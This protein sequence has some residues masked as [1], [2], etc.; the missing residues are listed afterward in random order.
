[1]SF[2]PTKRLLWLVFAAALV[3]VAAGPWAELQP[4]WLLAMIGIGLTALADMAVSLAR[5]RPPG[6]SV[7]AVVRFMRDREG[8]VP[9]TFANADSRARRL[10]FALGLPAV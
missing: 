4:V 6:A 1:M 5:A 9:V 8:V 2:V 7:P 3:G 10:R